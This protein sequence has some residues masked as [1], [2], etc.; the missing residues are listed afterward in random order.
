MRI[1]IDT[2]VL[3]DYILLREPFTQ[4]AKKIIEL[5]QKEILNG[6]MAAQSVADMF[7]ILRK[8]IPVES[9]R[10][11]LL[12]LCDILHVE[13][14]DKAKLTRALRNQDFSDFEDCLQTECAS[15]FK[16]D[17]IITRNVRD[18]AGSE[19]PCLTPK[20]FCTLFETSGKEV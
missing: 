9:R 14:I 10:R 6:A 1:L 11:I 20:D 12:N 16:A 2:N 4:D 18:Y 3:L 19:I 17:Y 15:T 5:C 7:Y 13:S 8:D